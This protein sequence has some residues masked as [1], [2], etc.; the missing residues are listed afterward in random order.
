MGRVLTG[1]MMRDGRRLSIGRRR[2]GIPSLPHARAAAAIGDCR[3]I[4][5]ALNDGATLEGLRLL[6][7]FR[8]IKDA[9]LR[10]RAV[11]YVE[12]LSRR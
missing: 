7:A 1:T 6:K 10:R 5:D 8:Q 11:E 4:A 9:A 12:D 2:D 3:V